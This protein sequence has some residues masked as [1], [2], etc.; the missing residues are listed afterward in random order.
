[1]VNYDGLYNKIYYGDNLTANYF[2]NQK[3]YFKIIDNGTI[4][5]HKP[6]T[7]NGKWTWGFGGIVDSSGKY[8]KESFV[9][10]ITGGGTL[11]LKKCV[12]ILQPSFTWECFLRSGGIA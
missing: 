4:L 5:P 10:S 2:S 11:R 9:N 1:M 8:L 3:L 7:I 6:L 12:I